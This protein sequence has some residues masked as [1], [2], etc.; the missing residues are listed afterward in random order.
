MTVVV[1]PEVD[2]NGVR[3]TFFLQMLAEVVGAELVCD[4]ESMEH[5]ET[6]SK[7]LLD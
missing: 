4:A 3:R 7:D 6:T 1:A 2:H 5:L